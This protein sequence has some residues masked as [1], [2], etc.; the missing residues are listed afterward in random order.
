MNNDLSVKM[1]MAWLVS[2]YEMLSCDDVRTARTNR[3]T[4]GD[5][6]LRYLAEHYRNRNFNG[7]YPHA[8]EYRDKWYYFRRGFQRFCR[9]WYRNQVARQEKRS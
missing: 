3:C 6:K 7:H 2:Q 1:R 8:Y 4:C 9:T 5:R